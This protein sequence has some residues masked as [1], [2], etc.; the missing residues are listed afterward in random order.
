MRADGLSVLDQVLISAYKKAPNALFQG[1]AVYKNDLN[2]QKII[3]S[4][5]S[6]KPDIILVGLGFP[7][8]EIWLHDNLNKILSAKIGIGIGG[9]FDF[10]TGRAKRAPKI[11]QSIGL[12]W[13]LAVI[14]A[15]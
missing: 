14:H 10:W 5:K 8:Q 6:Q 4:L 13:L 9:T 7:E 15:T 2:N 11:M 3:E 1:V 12:E